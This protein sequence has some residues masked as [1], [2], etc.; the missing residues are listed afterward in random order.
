M[1]FHHIGDVN[2]PSQTSFE[3]WSLGCVVPGPVCTVPHQ[4]A[5]MLHVLSYVVELSLFL[6]ISGLYHQ[7]PDWN[8][9]VWKI[10]II[11]INF[12]CIY[13]I[14]ESV[15]VMDIGIFVE[16]NSWFTLRKHAQR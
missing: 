3:H 4:W 16:V 11:F 15:N 1:R 5:T 9:A 12:H 6:I 7:T 8:L 2:L 10:S 14:T 13:T